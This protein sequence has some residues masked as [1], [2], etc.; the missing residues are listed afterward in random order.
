MRRSRTH[1]LLQFWAAI[2]IAIGF[3]TVAASGASASTATAATAAGLKSIG[4]ATATGK[5]ISLAKGKAGI[6]LIGPN[7]HALYIFTKDQGTKTA[8]LGQ[9]AT[10]WPALTDTGAITTGPDINKAEVAKVDAQK[11]DQLTYYGHLLYYFK[12]D[13]A[14]GQTNGTKIKDW[15]LLGPFGNVMLPKA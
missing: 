12:G 8:C 5:T 14:P 2:V 15:D 9:C 3:G 6:F 13:S 1:K 10:F 11:P 4:P 7:G